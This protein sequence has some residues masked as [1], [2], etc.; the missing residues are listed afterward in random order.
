M[1]SL[2]CS[3]FV[4][5]MFAA[6]AA[7]SSIFLTAGCGSSNGIATRN[8]VGFSNSSLTGTYVFSSQGSDAAN[9]VLLTMAGALI[10]DGGGHILTGGTMDIMGADAGRNTNVAI[11]A[12][13]YNVG[14]DGRGQAQLNTA[15]GNFELDFVLTSSSHGLV[16]EFDNSGSGSGTVDLQ[17]AVPTLNQLAGSYAFGLGGIDPSGDPLASAGSIT[18]DSTGNVLTGSVFDH[19]GDGGTPSALTGAATAPSGTAPGTLSLNGALGG[20]LTFDFYPIDATHLKFIETD[21]TYAILSGDVF[22][23]ASATIPNGQMVFTM[24]GG[25]FTTGPLAVGGVVTSNGSGSFSNGLEDYN[26]NGN[27][28]PAQ[29]SFSGTLNA[30]LSGPGS[31]VVTTLTTFVPATQWA[32]Y[33]SSGGLIMLET[34]ALNVSL[35]TG[36]LQSSTSFAASQNYGFNISA[37]NTSGGVEEDDIAQ[38]LTQTGSTLKGAVDVND[39]GA[40]SPPQTLTGSYT[41]PDATGRG[42]A[43]T[44]AAGNEFVSFDFY[45]ANSSTVL[46][47]ETDTNQIGSG[48]IE[49]Q[50]APPGSMVASHV[51]LAHTM[52]RIRAALK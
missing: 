31:R 8:P 50:S 3:K 16:T 19:S 42:T 49:L 23:Q 15:V 25:T 28:N 12:G 35:G 47:L 4:L 36:Y 18:L 24:A 46:V 21:F 11:T 32:L 52:P 43:T 30:G 41:G 2:A 29:V 6:L 5:R 7:I 51:S 38:F 9:G 44:N 39:E 22:S 27:V 48:I 1:N 40:T 34:D 33:P 26:N 14:S 45:V 20:G 37:F 10:A 17:T 13:N